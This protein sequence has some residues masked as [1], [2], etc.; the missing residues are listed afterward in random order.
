MKTLARQ[1]MLPPPPSLS[2]ACAASLHASWARVTTFVQGRLARA[3]RSL[4]EG[5]APRPS[6][7]HGVHSSLDW[8]ATEPELGATVAGIRARDT[9]YLR[10]PDQRLGASSQREAVANAVG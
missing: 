5:L 10:R 1:T 3:A 8:I 4:Q 2:L 6:C 9:P 7:D